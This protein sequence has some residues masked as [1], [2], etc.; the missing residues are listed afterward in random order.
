MG[1]LGRPSVAYCVE[2]A[3]G[4]ARRILIRYGDLARWVRL[5]V[6]G[7]LVLLASQRAAAFPSSRL[8]YVRGPGAEDCPDQVAVR[9]AVKKRLGY[10]PF[11]PSSDKTIIARV[12]RE[13]DQLRGEVELVDEHGT[14]VGRREFSAPV[15]QCDQLVRAMALSI[16]I[17]IDPKSA[18][19]YNQGP[20]ESPRRIRLRIG[21]NRNKALRSSPC[22]PGSGDA[23]I[24]PSAP[25]AK[26]SAAA[27]H[28]QWS[29]G[30]GPT[31]QFRSLP[32][33]ALGA[34]AFAG[35]AAERVVA[36]A[37]DRV[38]FAGDHDRTKR[39]AR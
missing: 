33:T 20:E 8:V 2:A 34:T 17:A 13:A 32:Q 1:V 28:W 37:R 7:L 38:G 21:R 23:S 22:A 15:D 4:H 3:F 6:F 16:S 27:H 25:P 9:E 26:A 35:A 5:L 31:L 36:R 11:F 18:E 24:Q 14:Q 12:L 39:R 30:L 10:D 19:T 29:V